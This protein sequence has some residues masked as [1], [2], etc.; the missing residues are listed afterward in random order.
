MTL[1]PQQKLPAN[2][3]AEPAPE[4]LSQDADEPEGVVWLPGEE[5]Y[6]ADSESNL[7]G[8]AS[9]E[10]GTAWSTTARYGIS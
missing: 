10:E 8:S 7:E 9:R 4:S 5:G 6:E 2:E 1:S 3:G